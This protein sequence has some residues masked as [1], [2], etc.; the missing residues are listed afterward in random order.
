MKID[1]R[2]EKVNKITKLVLAVS[3]SGRGY[4]IYVINKVLAH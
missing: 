3:L 4:S 1:V 2:T